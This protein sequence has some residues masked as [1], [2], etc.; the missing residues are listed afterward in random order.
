LI[1][2]FFDLTNQFNYGEIPKD[3]LEPKIKHLLEKYN[4]DATEYQDLI[5][6]SRHDP[7]I[8]LILIDLQQ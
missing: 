5:Y 1:N 7:E 6:A 2:E 3:S 8:E 4:P